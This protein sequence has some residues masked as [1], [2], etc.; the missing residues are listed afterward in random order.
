MS[1]TFHGRLPSRDSALGLRLALRARSVTMTVI[2]T[3]YGVN[4]Y[5]LSKILY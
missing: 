5:S 2:N 3:D 1:V 4:D